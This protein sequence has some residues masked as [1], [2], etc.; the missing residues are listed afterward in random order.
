MNSR[1]GR[2]VATVTLLVLSTS[3]AASSV[4][5][6]EATAG[7]VTRAEFRKVDKGSSLAR[8]HRVFDTAGSRFYFDGGGG[9]LPPAQSRAYDRC[10]GGL[11]TVFSEKHRGVWRLQDKSWSA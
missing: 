1:L 5:P 3:I 6:A 2:A 9:G 4:A 7:C 11:A 10:P 8:V